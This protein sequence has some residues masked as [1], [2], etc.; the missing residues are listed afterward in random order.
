MFNV[1]DVKKMLEMAYS[2]GY[3]LG[4]EDGEDMKSTHEKCD[5]DELLEMAL[6]ELN[7]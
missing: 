6:E 5:V 7:K 2:I 3:D 1:N 4:W